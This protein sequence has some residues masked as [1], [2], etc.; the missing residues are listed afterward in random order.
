MTG[1][2]RVNT[3]R[4]C[5][6]IENK[7]QTIEEMLVNKIARRQ[8]NWTSPLNAPPSLNLAACIEQARIQNPKM[9]LRIL[10]DLF[11]AFERGVKLARA[12]EA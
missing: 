12:A 11:C 4:L 5:P 7:F 6:R 1:G 8:G 3:R 9:N 10:T 2:F